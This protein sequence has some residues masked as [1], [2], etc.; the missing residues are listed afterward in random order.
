MRTGPRPTPGRFR[1][2]VITSGVTPS[3][4]VDYKHATIKQYHKEGRALR[5]ET[6]IN[7]TRDFKIGKRLTN[8][9]ALREV[10]FSATGACCASNDSATTRSP[11][12]KPA[13]RRHRPR[14]HR[15]RN[16]HPRPAPG[17]GPQPRPA[18]RATDLPAPTRRL[19]QPR[20][21]P[22]HRRTPRPARRHH[23]PDHLRPAPAPQPPAHRTDPRPP[24]ATASPTPA[25]T[26]PCSSPA[27]TTASCPPA[28]PSSPRPPRP[29]G[30]LRAR[31]HRLPESHR[32]A[33]SATP[34]SPHDT[35]RHHQP[36]L[37]QSNRL[38]RP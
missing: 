5:T 21:A 29:P 23:R 7:D 27:S 10:G 19:H 6:T 33:S 26:P 17:P 31:R 37:T 9:P 25:C 38:R 28:W 30:K 13:H 36:N 14:P 20:P 8:L 15:Q 35:T 16:P 34:D 4:H 1:T 11:E 32:P 22:A 12:P 3:L 2:R 18:G 24:T